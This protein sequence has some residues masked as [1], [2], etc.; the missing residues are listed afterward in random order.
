V[1]AIIERIF[2]FAAIVLFSVILGFL[3]SQ[4]KIFPYTL[5]V[6]SKTVI[7]DLVIWAKLWARGE[8]KEDQVHLIPS[9][10]MPGPEEETRDRRAASD[11]FTFMSRFWNGRFELALVDIEGAVVHSWGVPDAVYDAAGARILPL[12]RGQYEIMGSHLFPNGDVLFIINYRVMA[13]LDRCSNLQW[14]FHESPHHDLEVLDDGRIWVATRKLR[15]TKHSATRTYNDDQI[16]LLSPDGIILD[17]IS[18]YEAFMES[19]YRGVLLEGSS[20][21]PSV[22]GLDVMHLNDIDIVSLPFSQ[23]HDF[24][25]PGDFLVS[26]RRPDSVAIIDRDTRRVKWALTGAFLRQHDPDLLPDGSILVFDNR[27]DKSQF[28]GARHLVEPQRFGYSRVVQLNPETQQILWSYEGTPERPFYTSIHGG[29]QQLPNGNVLITESEGGR[30][31]EIEKES[32]RTVWEFRNIVDQEDG[33]VW[34]GRIT[35]AV[36]YPPDYPRFLHEPCP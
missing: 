23:H 34:L 15:E 7:D 20:D 27:T 10:F 32:N 35:E 3:I 11:G 8:S 4:Y 29:Q 12:K 36:R 22:S 33:L 31:F 17:R 6:D 13:K 21:Y 18:V 30:V 9:T 2:F 26:L 25:D 28:N 19:D 1:L 24:A 5:M 16:V 14:I